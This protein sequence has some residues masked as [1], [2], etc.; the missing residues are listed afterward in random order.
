MR[1]KIHF[2][3]DYYIAACTAL[4]GLGLILRLL[5]LGAMEFWWDEFVTIGRAQPD[6]LHLL[7]GL[8]FQSP[9]PVSTDCSPPLHHI[10]VHM[11]LAFGKSEAVIKLPSVLCGFI[12]IF[13]FWKL[14]E[15]IFGRRTALFILAFCSLSMFH[16]YYSRDIR[17]YSTFFA[18][19][20]ASLFCLDKALSDKK[21]KYWALFSLTTAFSLYT[22][23][24]SATYI[25]GQVVFISGTVILSLTRGNTPE[26]KK[27]AIAA[28]LSFCA[29]LLLYSPWIPGQYFAFKSFLGPG[30]YISF[31]IEPLASS[32]RFFLEY[33]YQGKFN[34]LLIAL[35]LCALGISHGLLTRR[36][37]RGT[38]L[39]L[40]YTL[41][42][43]VVL[44]RVETQFEIHPKYVTSLFFFLVFSLALGLNALAGIAS[45]A[46]GSKAAN[47]IATAVFLA[48]ISSNFNYLSF[49]Q[50]KMVSAK[51]TFREIALHAHSGDHI[52]FENE[53][54]FSFLGDW[55][56][57]K[58]IPSARETMKRGYKRCLLAFEHPLQIPGSIP[59]VSNKNLQLSRVGFVSAS[60]IVAHPQSAG[61][62]RYADDFRTFKLFN[63]A[64][65]TDN[66]TADLAYGGL[67]PADMSR[68]GRVV[69]AFSLPR[70]QEPSGFTVSIRAMVTE[71]IGLRSDSYVK[72]FAGASPESLTPAGH[73]IP[74][75]MKDKSGTYTME[76][77]FPLDSVPAGAKTV[78]IAV[79]FFTGT[80]DGYMR[81]TDIGF[82]SGFSGQAPN[83][84]AYEQAVA[85]TLASANSLSPS[86]PGKGT[87]RLGSLAA[88]RLTG[89][90]VRAPYGDMAGREA[91]LKAHP[92]AQPVYTASNKGKPFI[93]IYDPWLDPAISLE[94]D[95]QLALEFPERL[96]GLAV[97]GGYC[98]ASMKWNGVPL[99]LTLGTPPSSA[100]FMNPGGMGY[101][102]FSPVFKKELFTP[103]D[104]DT[105]RDIR[106]L[107]PGEC[108]TCMKEQPCY[109]TYK[110]VSL[111]PIER[112]V[113][114]SY[115]RM[116]NDAARKNS[117]KLSVSCD[118]GPFDPVY[119]LNSTG[120]LSGV[121][122]A[123]PRVDEYLPVKPAKAVVVRLDMVNEG[124]QWWST[125]ENPM[126]F[127]LYYNTAFTVETKDTVAISVSSGDQHFLITP[128]ATPYDPSEI[129]RPG[130]LITPQLR[131]FFQ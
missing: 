88:F 21:T 83:D 45:K 126:T 4:L 107:P 104:F 76:G 40:A 33:F 1:T 123:F 59:L 81:I 69:Y 108:I 2:R 23:Y 124:S 109:A 95:E 12:S 55:Y 67:V 6:L 50:G 29:A 102:L 51:Q 25:L 96:G 111:F 10:L 17:W 8:Y 11:A 93:E 54:Q 89:G 5:F 82:T 61:V 3:F 14:S 85:D 125:Q 19:T 77:R 52:L 94:G 72:L 16:I 127:E 86:Q 118:G 37:R 32:F 18:C 26:A 70:D 49:Y 116:I 48:V 75:E 9:S 128:S 98:P 114:T 58:S 20:T 42:P 80:V 99:P 46:V 130:L 30:K 115:P 13:F 112:I 39:M 87:L 73:L 24:T 120:D 103:G 28:F 44:Y 84:G 110:F 79:E 129:L 100:S 105:F 64:W 60:P 74:S 131:R 31:N 117:L 71:R 41:M 68:P 92:G 57:G 15:R 65:S 34:L 27:T 43:I 53:R 121:G 90:A 63:D 101:T 38:L 36:L 35:P 91:Y 47:V 122:G 66:A 113:I 78:Y 22:S 62:F 56:L 7:R 97:S 106:I 119:A